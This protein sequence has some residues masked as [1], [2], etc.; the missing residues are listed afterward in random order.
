LKI[1]DSQAIQEYKYI[2]LSCIKYIS[3]VQL[4]APGP[5]AAH[6][7]VF[8]GLRKHSGK[9]FKSEIC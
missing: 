7:S 1:F 5:H 6:H 2:F 3:V 9:I 4:Q 8:S